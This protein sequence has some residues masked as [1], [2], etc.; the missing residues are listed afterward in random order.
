MDRLL[1]HI[2]C[3]PCGTHVFEVLR[4]QFQLTG[5]L[6]NPNIHPEDEYRRRVAEARRWAEEVGLPLIEGPY[7]PEAWFQLTEGMADEPEGGERCA[8]CFR[9]RLEATAEAACREGFA[10]FATTLTVGPTKRAEVVNR[11]GR[12]IAE[13]HGLLFFE[14]DFKKR[15]GFQHSL[16]LSRAFALYRQD[17]CGCV[18][19]LRARRARG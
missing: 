13:C 4:E 6:Y 9:T 19:S 1:L 12:E 2:C 3:G 18:Y 15:G 14:A 5:Y 11:I 8:L 10:H 7:E 17:Y 16:E